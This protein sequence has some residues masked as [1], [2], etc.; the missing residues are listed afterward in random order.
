M[1]AKSTKSEHPSRPLETYLADL[2][3]LDGS[4]TQMMTR[5]LEIC[6][7]WQADLLKAA[8]PLTADWLERRREG[9]NAA[10]DALERL[11]R[12]TDLAEAASIQRDWFDGAT[13][14]L[15]SDIGALTAQAVALSEEAVVATRNAAQSSAE[16][17]ASLKPRAVEKETRVDAAA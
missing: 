14:R 7:R 5:P 9:T 17:V 4:M 12:C 6:L 2:M 3:R 1:A 8:E 15:N 13:K 16:A 10:L 11:A